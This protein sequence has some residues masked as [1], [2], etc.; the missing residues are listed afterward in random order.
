MGGEVRGVD[1][2][3]PSSVN[4]N[5]G[6][7]VD[8][9]NPGPE[10]DDMNGPAAEEDE[11]EEEK[12][13]YSGMEYA[14]GQP[15]DVLDTVGKWSEAEV[16]DV[17]LQ[18]RRV[19]ITYCFWSDN[20]N[21]WLDFSSPRIAKWGAHTYQ[22]GGV[23]RLNQRIECRDTYQK[24]LEALVIEC[25]PDRVKVHYH[26]WHHK[27]DEWL[28]RNSERIRP[29]GRMKK[30]VKK[31]PAARLLS[32]QR[33]HMQGRV[34]NIVSTSQQ[35]DRYREALRSQ[36]LHV[37]PVDGDGNCMFRSVSHQVYGDDQHHMLVRAMCMDYMESE[38]HYFEPY[39]EGNMEDFLAYLNHKRQNGTW[40]D[41][42]EVQALCELYNRPAEIWG[43]DPATGG[44]KLRTFHEV[45]A[46]G[47]HRPPMRLSFYGGG[48]YDSIVGPDHH[49]HLLQTQPGV[50]ERTRI[51]WSQS[52]GTGTLEETK[53]QSDLAATEE[54]EIEAALRESRRIFDGQAMDLECIFHEQLS[55]VAA[56]A[57]LERTQDELM[58][59]VA[60]QSA[61][62]HDEAQSL[63]AIHRSEQFELEQAM[64]LS[65][66]VASGPVAGAAAGMID[67]D[68]NLRRAI[69]LSQ[70]DG[71]DE[72]QRA[73]AISSGG[74]DE[75]ESD[76]LQRAIALSAQSSD[77]DPLLQYALAMSQEGASGGAAAA[78][79]EEDQILA[80]I[81]LSQSTS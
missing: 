79:D 60:A 18:M 20:F 50:T 80:A 69:A 8:A 40:G 46:G 19:H 58:D 78:M 64:A 30:L 65:A 21:E 76:E 63:E 34:R 26:N 37:R 75:A 16:I 3:L 70:Q 49:Q 12:T 14:I 22:I 10:V 42:P 29:Y 39:V 51:Q 77:Q 54:A 1:A 23:L 48:H 13:A 59:T 35:Y 2:L 7:G 61:R 17:D 36:G 11:E 66:G 62:E 31:P 45:S 15:L 52:R 71:D 27:Y 25:E 28:P 81:Q 74:T 55:A 44:K 73:L 53:Q 56:Q 38:K 5:A 67:D 32:L 24:W 4:P 57:D 72:L 47:H 33:S 9:G 41:D 6:S 43:F 68:E